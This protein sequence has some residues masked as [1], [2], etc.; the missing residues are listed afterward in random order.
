M[1]NPG[2]NKL[3]HTCF[4]FKKSAFFSEHITQTIQNNSIFPQGMIQYTNR[5][6]SY[7]LKT[8]LNN[9]LILMSTYFRT[10]FDFLHIL[11]NNIVLINNTASIS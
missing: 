3:I 11:L 6:H 5:N 2:L 9:C 10:G 4:Q 7:T 8:S 1:E